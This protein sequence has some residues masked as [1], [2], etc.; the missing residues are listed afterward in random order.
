MNKKKKKPWVTVLDIPL[1]EFMDK[2][3]LVR[4]DLNKSV[5][6]LVCGE[7]KTVNIPFKTEEFIGLKSNDC[8]CKTF[9]VSP[10]YIIG[11]IF[12]KIAEHDFKRFGNED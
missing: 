7:I 2:Y 11:G 8:S 5:T 9:A 6:C 12:K 3:P 10:L 4:E 1:E